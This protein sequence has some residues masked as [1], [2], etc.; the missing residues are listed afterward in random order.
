[1]SQSEFL[2]SAAQLRRLAAKI[3]DPEAHRRIISVAEE[4]EAMAHGPAAVDKQRKR[5]KG[6]LELITLMPPRG[7]PLH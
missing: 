3:S 7:K 6:H 1:M 5:S 4:Y 2:K